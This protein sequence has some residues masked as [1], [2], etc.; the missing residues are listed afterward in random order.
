MGIQSY[1]NYMLPPHEFQS[2]T[3]QL[4][5]ILTR[6]KPLSK[7]HGRQVAIIFLKTSTFR[8][9]DK[10]SNS[11]NIWRKLQGTEAPL[12]SENVV[13]SIINYAQ[14]ITIFMSAINH[15]QMGV[16]HW[17]SHIMDF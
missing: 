13:N 6:A 15:P 5:W 8:S 7:F 10:A 4:S 16:Y 12:K 9:S 11:W 2:K 3:R 1:I 17:V 14:V